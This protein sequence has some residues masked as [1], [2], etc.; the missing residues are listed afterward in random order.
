MIHHEGTKDTKSTK[1]S[2]LALSHEVIGASI[3]VH[4][5]LGPGLLESIY[6]M[7]LCRELWLRGIE[8]ERQV[9]IPVNYKGKRLPCFVQLDLLVK[10]TIIIELKSAQKILPVHRAQ[11]L[12]YLR[13]REL[14]LGLIINFNVEV[15]K[16]GVRRVLNG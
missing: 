5:L 13:L 16:D 2:A 8:V 1:S 7:A 10:R 9:N 4:R 6:E 11:L 12:T 3:E 14:W 15:L